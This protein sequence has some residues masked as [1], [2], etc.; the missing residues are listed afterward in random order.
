M[1]CKVDVSDAILLGV[2]D[3]MSAACLKAVHFDAVIICGCD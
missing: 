2:Q 3:L 1:V